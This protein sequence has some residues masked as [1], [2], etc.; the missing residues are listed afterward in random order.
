[1]RL[2]LY[3]A[4]LPLGKWQCGKLPRQPAGGTVGSRTLLQCRRGQRH[5]GE[6]APGIQHQ[7]TA[8]QPGLPDS[9]G[10]G[11]AGTSAPGYALRSSSRW[12]IPPEP[13]ERNPPT[14]LI[15]NCPGIGVRPGALDFDPSIP[16]S[17]AP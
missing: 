12:K 3:P 1:N 17:P 10:G 4:R 11:E 5:A 13:I 6:L 9:G 15:R 16:R 2:E 14:T 7:E 8:W